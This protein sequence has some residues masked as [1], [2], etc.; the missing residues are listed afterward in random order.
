MRNTVAGARRSVFVGV[1]SGV[2]MVAELVQ[3][4]R[5]AVERAAAAVN[6]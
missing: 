4:A 6:A 3:K 1:I 2:V 5:A